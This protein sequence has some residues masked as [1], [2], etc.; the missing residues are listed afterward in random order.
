MGLL[1]QLCQ[2]GAVLENGRIFFYPRVERA[3]EHH[4]HITMGTLP[5]WMRR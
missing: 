5:A 2:S 1:R 4:E 3:I